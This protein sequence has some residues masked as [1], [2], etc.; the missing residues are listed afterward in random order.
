MVPPDGHAL[1]LIG[2]GMGIV[3]VWIGREHGQGHFRFNRLV[4]LTVYPKANRGIIR[5]AMMHPR[6]ADTPKII[7]N[8]LMR[9]ILK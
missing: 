8:A 6:A 1:R 9:N 3:G 5:T 4:M 2:F 7:N